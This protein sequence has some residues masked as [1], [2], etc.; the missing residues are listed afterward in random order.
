MA[1]GIIIRRA[2]HAD[3]DAL[4][5]LGA[6]LM[7][8]HFAFDATR[9]LAPGENAESG[10]AFFLTSQLD[11]DDSLVMVA[12]RAAAIVGYVFAGIEPMS[13]K[14]LRGPAGFIHDL[15]VVEDARGAGMGERLLEAAVAWLTE[16]GVPR[17]ML[18]TAAPNEG[19]Q[20]LFERHGFRRTM[21]EMTR[22]VPGS[23]T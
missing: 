6:A 1:A 21:I 14:E 13:W 11:S 8:A 9:F 16:H 15:L 18:W 2:T 4:G 3:R 19:A 23:R 5:Q 7:H 20:R 10:Y 17:V 12:E 22:D